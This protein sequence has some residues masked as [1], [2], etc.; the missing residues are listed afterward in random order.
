[1]TAMTFEL[2]DLNYFSTEIIVSKKIFYD[3]RNN[4]IEN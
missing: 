1:M 4:L 3:F 2:R